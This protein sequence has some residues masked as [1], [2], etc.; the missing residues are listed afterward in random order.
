MLIADARK[1]RKRVA[2][3]RPSLSL[4]RIATFTFILGNRLKADAR[5]HPPR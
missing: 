4:L 3:C 5:L 1:A 2:P